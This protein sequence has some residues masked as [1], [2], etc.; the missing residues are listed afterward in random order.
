MSYPPLVNRGLA[1]GTSSPHSWTER[2]VWLG[3]GVQAVS[4]QA[5]IAGSNF[6]IS[7]LLARWL[8]PSDYGAYALAFAGFF[9]VSLIYQTL[10]L[11][12]MSVFG[13]SDYRS[14][15]AAYLRVLLG[16]HA[17]IAAITLVVMG[18]AS[19]LARWLS[20]SESLVGALTG[21]TI[22]APCI[23]LFWLARRIHYIQFG[24][25][26]SLLGACLYCAIVLGGLWVLTE[27]QS[28]SPLATFLLMSF[29]ALAASGLLFTRAELFTRNGDQC[30]ATKQ[31]WAKHWQFGKWILLSSIAWW[32]P[33]NFY[34]LL[35]GSASQI[36]D[37]AELKSL[38]NLNLPV[39]HT[40]TALF[41]LLLPY[42]ASMHSH[43]ETD[44]LTVLARKIGVL[45]AGGA[46]VYWLL[47][48]LYR[49]QVVAYLYQGRYQATTN[50]IPIVA[51]ASLMEAAFLGPGIALR[52]ARAT[53]LIFRAHS[54]S[55]AV[56]IV[57][58]TP[59][60]LLYGLTGAIT[61]MFLA[62]LT[63]LLY[64]S[65]LLRRTF[66]HRG[67]AIGQG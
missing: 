38:L 65:F 23:L 37:A 49:E 58:G 42:A 60:T 16:M 41:V 3:K 35:L 22:A 36:S 26:T 13:S 63:A 34:Y 59:A 4:D 19:F 51:A 21:A 5:L 33:G 50:L 39:G 20:D 10:I 8:A 18:A 28:I 61:S 9:L 6:V 43:S 57:V 66:P 32:I 30:P 24:P 40:F 11:E 64:A 7:V 47:L 12:P 45:F 25:F 55:S 56:A 14:S 2:L 15:Q 54:A 67:K 27:R 1:S 53:A 46:G 31:I 48:I 62:S 29:A 52:S 44:G 17:W